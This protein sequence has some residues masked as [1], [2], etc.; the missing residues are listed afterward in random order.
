ML[1]KVVIEYLKLKK[2]D[3]KRIIKRFDEEMTNHPYSEQTI[4]RLAN[5]RLEYLSRY[6]AVSKTINTLTYVIK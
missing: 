1:K 3:L 5:E 4:E 6:S 2:R